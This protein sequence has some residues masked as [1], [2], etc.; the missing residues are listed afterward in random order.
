MPDEAAPSLR[1]R[2][3]SLEGSVARLLEAMDRRDWHSI[4]REARDVLSVVS[5]VLAA[6]KALIEFGGPDR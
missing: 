1:A 2:M 4:D 5:K 6:A 3:T